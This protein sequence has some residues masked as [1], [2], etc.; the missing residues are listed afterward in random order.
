MS[1]LVVVLVLVH[2]KWPIRTA[3][4][5]VD[6]FINLHG[7][8]PV[9]SVVVSAWA[10][11][12]LV[13]RPCLPE[14]LKDVALAEVC[15]VAPITW[16]SRYLAIAR[17][18]VRWKIIFHRVSVGYL[19]WILHTSV[20]A[21]SRRSVCILFIDDHW[22]LEILQPA[23]AGSIL[24]L[25]EGLLVSSVLLVS[26]HLGL[27]SSLVHPSSGTVYNARLGNSWILSGTQ[28]SRSFLRLGLGLG[29]VSR[30]GHSGGDFSSEVSLRK[31]GGVWSG[32][33][34]SLNSLLSRLCSWRLGVRAWICPCSSS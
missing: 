9:G 21:L 25:E 8:Y 12:W 34:V 10:D 18:S 30:C 14:S 22:I 15:H 33:D 5:L 17:G 31:L 2:H 27:Y 28:G 32:I 29:A 7:S 26:H 20:V 16:F 23:S 6:P 11:S 3:F 24:L 4:E 13:A 1:E 19:I